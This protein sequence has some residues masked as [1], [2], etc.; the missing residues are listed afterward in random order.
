MKKLVLMVK[1]EKSVLVEQLCAAVA[2]GVA[3]MKLPDVKRYLHISGDNSQITA[4]NNE[5]MCRYLQ[6]LSLEEYKEFFPEEYERSYE[7]AAD[8][9]LAQVKRDILF[10]IIE[11]TGAMVVGLEQLKIIKKGIVVSTLSAKEL[12]DN[13]ASYQK[14]FGEEGLLIVDKVALGTAEDIERQAGEV[15]AK[16]FPHTS[17]I[18]VKKESGVSFANK[19]AE[20]VGE[21]E[22]IKIP[23]SSSS[24]EED[25]VVKDLAEVGSLPKD[26]T[27]A[28]PVK[29]IMIPVNREGR[30]ELERFAYDNS[31]EFKFLLRRAETKSLEEMATT[32][33]EYGMLYLIAS[34]KSTIIGILL[35]LTTDILEH[36]RSSEEY[37]VLKAKKI[38]DFLNKH[39][40]EYFERF[41]LPC[42]SNQKKQELILNLHKASVDEVK[43]TLSPEIVRL[44]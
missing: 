22:E 18:L 43:S 30:K 44:W 25:E 12:E 17:K 33:P 27:A 15:T 40:P 42:S 31:D 36:G 24:P 14:L 37:S 28:P 5:Y 32:A 11:Q 16:L 10:S 9:R 29:K 39:A 41:I 4:V 8:V 23:T 34:C 6:K 3:N 19:L 35:N 13:L 20:V 7:G 26:E 1:D 2:Q 38:L 21:H